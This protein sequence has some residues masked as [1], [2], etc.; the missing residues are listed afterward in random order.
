MTIFVPPPAFL[1]A[2]G[3]AVLAAVVPRRAVPQLPVSHNG[4]VYCLIL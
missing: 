3:G 2:P 1:G 4:R